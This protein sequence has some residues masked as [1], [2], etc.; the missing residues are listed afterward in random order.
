MDVDIGDFRLVWFGLDV[1]IVID[2]K[3]GAEFYFWFAGYSYFEFGS[4][5]VE[6]DRLNKLS[7]IRERQ[8]FRVRRELRRG[9]GLRCFYVVRVLSFFRVFIGFCWCRGDVFVYEVVI[10][11]YFKQRTISFFF[12]GSGLLRFWRVRSYC[13]IVV[14]ICEG[15]FFWSIV[16]VVETGDRLLRRLQFFY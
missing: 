16:L 11:V 12:L 7:W 5:L 15:L 4:V 13:S 10:Q 8:L 14:F 2:S 9:V 6:M 1:D 3:W